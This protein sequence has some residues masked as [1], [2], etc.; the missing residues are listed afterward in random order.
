MA[1]I[2]NISMRHRVRVKNFRA[3]NNSLG[4]QRCCIMI[5]D[6]FTQ[7]FVLSRWKHVA[8]SVSCYFKQ[9]FTFVLTNQRCSGIGK[10]FDV[11]GSVRPLKK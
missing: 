7:H 5:M 3:E 10:D 11:L 8:R 6:F 1:M 9:V 4:L 2:L